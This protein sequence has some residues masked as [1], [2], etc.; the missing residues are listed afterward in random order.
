M[1]IKRTAF[2]MCMPHMSLLYL[3]P[4]YH[5]RSAVQTYRMNTSSYKMANNLCQYHYLLYV[6]REPHKS[7]AG[8]VPS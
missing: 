6:C 4:P 5:S 3:Y 1:M 8:C 2:T 7:L